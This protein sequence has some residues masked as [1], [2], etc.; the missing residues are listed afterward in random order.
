MEGD[1]G[2]EEE[3][4]EAVVVTGQLVNTIARKPVAGGY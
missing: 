3:G 1:G 2:E 4:R